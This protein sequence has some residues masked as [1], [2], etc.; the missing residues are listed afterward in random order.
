MTLILLCIVAYLMG[1]IPF[2]FLISKLM[3]G[4]DVRQ[5]GSGNIGM[6]NVMRVGGK[7]PGILTFVADFS[8]GLIPVYLV[9]LFDESHSEL[10]ESVVAVLAVLGHIFPIFLKFRGGK[11]V[12]TTFGVLFALNWKIGLICASVWLLVFF[13][14]RISSLSALCML[15]TLPLVLLIGYWQADLPLF[16]LL[17][18]SSLSLFMMYLHKDNIS[19][20]RQGQEGKI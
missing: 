4:I 17:L 15:T 6:T 12:A 14:T 5:S 19:R 11:G 20:L 16:Q 1:A 3:L 8:K 18:L 10:W 2:G 13:K 7:I 9:I